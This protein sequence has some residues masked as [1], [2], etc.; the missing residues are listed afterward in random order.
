[1]HNVAFISLTLHSRTFQGNSF[2]SIAHTPNPHP[3]V[4][5]NNQHNY[6][7]PPD[8]EFILEARS[9]IHYHAGNE[10]SRSGRDHMTSPCSLAVGFSEMPA[11]ALVPTCSFAKLVT[12]QYLA[13][14]KEVCQEEGREQIILCFVM[15]LKGWGKPSMEHDCGLPSAKEQSPGGQECIERCLTPGPVLSAFRIRCLPI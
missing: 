5:A 8:P 13:R 1:M 2:N 7:L 4:L 9:W 15:S 10:L 14:I 3:G 6:C 11:T 12:T